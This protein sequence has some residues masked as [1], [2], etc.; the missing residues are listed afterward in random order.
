MEPDTEDEETVP[1]LVTK[2]SESVSKNGNSLLNLATEEKT[3][4]EKTKCG[5]EEMRKVFMDDKRTLRQNLQQLET[6]MLPLMV[7]GGLRTATCMDGGSGTISDPEEILI[8]KRIRML[9]TAETPSQ[10]WAHVLIRNTGNKPRIFK[11][12]K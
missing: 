4:E 2:N 8:P 11:A 12:S 1:A 7:E 9:N 3:E 5:F 10:Y 6:A